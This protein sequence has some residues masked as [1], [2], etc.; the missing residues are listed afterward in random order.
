MLRRRVQS[1]Q[2][3]SSL[4]NLA[5][6]N[7]SEGTLGMEQSVRMEERC[8]IASRAPGCAFAAITLERS[9]DDHYQLP[10]Y[11]IDVT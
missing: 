2:V 1:T 11:P 5:C 3:A 10:W 9:F 8:W 4:L 7:D 6:R